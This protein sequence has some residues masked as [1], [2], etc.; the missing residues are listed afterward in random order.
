MLALLLLAAV[1]ILAWCYASVHRPTSRWMITGAALGAVISPLSLGLYA[2]FFLF[3]IGLPTGLIGLVS[4]LFHGEPGYEAA[5]W[6]GLVPSHQLV[7]GVG[8]VYVEL[9]NGVFWWLLYGFAG[10]IVDRV[11]FAYLM[12]HE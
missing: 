2:T 11:R 5:M 3:P 10:F 1:P 4:L 8:Q 9:L 12:R 6:L 7:S